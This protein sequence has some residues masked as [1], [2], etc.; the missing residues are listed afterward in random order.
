MPNDKRTNA[1]PSAHQL[2]CFAC[3]KPIPSGKGATAHAIDEQR[4]DV[5][6]DCFTRILLAGIVG[7]LPP[8]GGPRLFTEVAKRKRLA[9][10]AKAAE[11]AATPPR[12]GSAGFIEVPGYLRDACEQIDAAVFSSDMLFDGAQ[13]AM[14]KGY[15][16]RWKKWIAE[17]ER[18]LREER[19]KA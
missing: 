6:P 19:R 9:A 14:L 5:G 18:D 17:Y 3:N 10:D 2:R 4:V 13:R 8:K 7:Y 11:D 15:I 16:A 1:T 12:V